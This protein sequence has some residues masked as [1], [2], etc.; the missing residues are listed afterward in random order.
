MT[1]RLHFHFSLSCIGEWNGNPFQCSCLENP[2]DGRSWWTAISGVAQS[3]TRLKRLSS[4]SSLTR[5][6]GQFDYYLSVK[7]G[8]PV[9]G[10]TL[11]R[12]NAIFYVKCSVQNLFKYKI[13]L[14]TISTTR[15]LLFQWQPYQ[16]RTSFCVKLGWS[17]EAEARWWEKSQTIVKEESCH[18]GQS[19]LRPP[20]DREKKRTKIFNNL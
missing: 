10:I 20:Q 6:L 7:S 3:Q 4:S 14:K 19:V 17:I 12:S 2:R 9:H 18:H 13:L 15:S 11:W 16:E 1:E 8:F 5:G